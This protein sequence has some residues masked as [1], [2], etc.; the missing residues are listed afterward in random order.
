VAQGRTWRAAGG[1][2]V[3][4]GPRQ[5]AEAPTEGRRKEEGKEGKEK[6]KGE[7]G[8][9]KRKERKRKNREKDLEELE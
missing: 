9:K 1:R 3:G 6:E 5:S 8:K 2:T 7:K 4:R